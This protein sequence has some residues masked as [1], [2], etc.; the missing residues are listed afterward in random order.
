M[1]FLKLNVHP[2]GHQDLGN[3][4]QGLI[5][6]VDSG[7]LGSLLK[8]KGKSDLDSGTMFQLQNRSYRHVINRYEMALIH[9]KKLCNFDPLS[10]LLSEAHSLKAEVKKSLRKE[11]LYFISIIRMFLSL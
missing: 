8:L 3:V 11:S 7:G 2:N 4:K 5:K 1:I 9:K 6:I 10:V